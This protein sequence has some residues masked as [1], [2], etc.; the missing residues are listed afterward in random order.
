MLVL[1]ASALVAFLLSESGHDVVGD[2]IAQGAQVCTANLAEVMS[3]L[4]R[5]GVPA[6]EAEQIVAEIP[7]VRADLDLDL[8]MRAGA[9][10]RHAQPLGLSFGDRICLALAARERQPA[11]TGD[12]DWLEVAPLI[13]V[14]VRLIR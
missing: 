12:R 2:A 14:E 6:D 1:D 5:G 7:I 9:M 10:I 3:V 11:L 13:G 4:V 8:A